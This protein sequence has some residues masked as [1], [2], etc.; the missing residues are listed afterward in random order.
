[1]YYPNGDPI[2]KSYMIHRETLYDSV[3]LMEY[4]GVIQGF[5]IDGDH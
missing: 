1:M 4:T 5:L 3:V 2:G